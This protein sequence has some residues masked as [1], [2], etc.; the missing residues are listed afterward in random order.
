MS[1]RADCRPCS[2]TRRACHSALWAVGS[3]VL[4]LVAA[5]YPGHAVLAQSAAAQDFSG[6]WWVENP[7]DSLQPVNGAPIPFTRAGKREYD[8]YRAALKAGKVEDVTKKYCLPDGLPRLL[9]APYPFEVVHTK[10]QVTFLH[11]A[12]HVYRAI[13]I[14]GAHMNPELLLES[15]MG[16]AV[17]RWEN[18]VL[19]IESIGFNAE[20][21]LDSSGLPH[22]TQLRV[23][24]RWRRIDDGRRLAVDIT[25][26]DPEF[27]SAPWT[28]RLTFASHN[29]VTIEEYVCGQKHRDSMQSGG[30]R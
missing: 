25:I 30:A 21:R 11:E 15:F 29:D 26:E 1:D 2:G 8:T 19:V 23:L 18:D 17:G 5:V 20:T 3:A 4:M 27:Y 24:E 28:T 12:R 22:G 16:D 7:P 9:T 10:G 6:I 13:P 14:N